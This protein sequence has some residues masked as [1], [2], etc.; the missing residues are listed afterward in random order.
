MATTNLWYINDVDIRATYGVIISSDKAN[1]LKYADPKNVPSHSWAEEHGTE[2]DLSRMRVDDY[3]IALQCI[4]ESDTSLDF[5]A[6][7]QA[8]FDFL[9]SPGVKRLRFSDYLNKEYKTF[10]RGM[11][12]PNLKTKRFNASSIH[13]FT[14]G[15]KLRVLVNDIPESGGTVGT[16]GGT[17]GG[18]T[19]GS[20]PVTLTSADGT[21]IAVVPPGQT[22]VVKGNS[23]SYNGVLQRV[24]LPGENVNVVSPYSKQFFVT[25]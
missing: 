13:I 3:D 22:Y 18:G 23:I 5:F 17:T 6:K 7:H 4:L 25:L 21:L 15:L 1:M 19:A 11:V 20:D 24:L 10:Y 2:Y 14:F 12:S 9:R 16:T 8:F